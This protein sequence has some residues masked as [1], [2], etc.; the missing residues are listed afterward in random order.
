MLEPSIDS[1]TVWSVSDLNRQVKA[2]L[3]ANFGAIWVRGEVSNLRVQPSG[4]SYFTLKDEG[5][6]IR[7]VLFR[8]D[9]I[10]M[11]T[12]PKE[13]EQFAVYGDLSVYE[14][15]GEYQI[16]IRHLLAIGEGRLNRE[17][18][19]LKKK[20][21]EEGLFDPDRKQSIPELPRRVAI[22]T[23]PTGAAFQ[24]FISILRRRDWRGEVLL[25]G[26]KVQGTA[27][28]AEILSA[29][30][31]AENFPKVD[32]I[33]IGRGGGS[34]E[35]LWA[36]NDET[37]V[38]AVSTC[39]IP[40][41][42]AVGHQIDFVLTD[43]TADFRAETPSAAAERIS[44]D[45]L[46]Q[47]E[48]LA[49]LGQSLQDTTSDRLDGLRAKLDLSEARI[50]S[51]SPKSRIESSYQRLD[52]LQDRLAYMTNESL[53]RLAM[54]LESF[55]QRLDGSSLKK[56]LKRGFTF[57]RDEKGKS[58]SSKSDLMQDQ[59]VTATFADG[60]ASLRVES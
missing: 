19:R 44:S 59:S 55:G 39:S 15:R 31:S 48:L 8:G 38:R 6:Q 35:D 41:I 13:G 57:L 11:E 9:A 27:A 1:E 21:N 50:K 46:R 45:F 22:V 18:E 14:P 17:F 52:D 7:A 34:A 25:F 26:A 54:K 56:T 3:E 12:L 20:L 47:R 37:L 24:D 23:S 49:I 36:F 32:L 58:I 53:A 43:F 51:V 10:R 5:S 60:D 30:R 2:C 42:S 33:V 40:V 16:R 4:H 29:L 28:P